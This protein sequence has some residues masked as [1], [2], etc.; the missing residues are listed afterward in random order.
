VR[1][2]RAT[3]TTSLADMPA[4]S[5]SQLSVPLNRGLRRLARTVSRAADPLQLRDTAT[6]TCKAL[7][8]SPADGLAEPATISQSGIGSRRPP[9]TRCAGEAKIFDTKPSCQR[10]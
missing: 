10:D 6:L 4:D 7:P 2:I 8:I 3:T 5:N 1:V 9:R